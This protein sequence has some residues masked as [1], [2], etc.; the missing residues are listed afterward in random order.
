M[1]KKLLYLVGTYRRL[2]KPRG[3]FRGG[4]HSARCFGG[5]SWCCT[6]FTA[7]PL[8]SGAGTATVDT[9]ASCGLR[10]YGPMAKSDCPDRLS[11][12]TAPRRCSSASRALLGASVCPR[13]SLQWY[14]AAC[15]NMH[16]VHLSLCPPFY[17][18]IKRPPSR[19]LSALRIEALMEGLEEET[20]TRCA[21]TPATGQHRPNQ[22][23]L[24]RSVF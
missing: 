1:G 3:R 16:A 2:V 14:D 18:G 13:A 6:L 12:R 19:G 15:S 24:Y 7:S 22:Q 4:R 21:A 11:A 5:R 10:K 9:A 23:R 17:I 8:L 20:M